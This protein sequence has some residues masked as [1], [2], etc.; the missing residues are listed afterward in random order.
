LAKVISTEAVSERLSN[1]YTEIVSGNDSQW[2]LYTQEA[3]EYGFDLSK[4]VEL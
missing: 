2:I 4:I 3:L 1:E